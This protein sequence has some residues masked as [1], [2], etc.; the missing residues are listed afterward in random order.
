MKTCNGC[1]LCCVLFPIKELNKG[2][3]VV[4]CHSTKEGCDIYANRLDSC[5]AFVCQWLIRQDMEEDLRPDR[6]GIIY[7]II[8]GVLFASQKSIYSHMNKANI[9]FMDGLRARKIVYKRQYY[10]EDGVLEVV[11]FKPY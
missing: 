4:C 11:S 10:N 5:R 2:T 6:C 9:I 1:N 8:D 7:H 3:N